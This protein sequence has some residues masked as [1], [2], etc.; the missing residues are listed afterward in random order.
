MERLDKI[1]GRET[2]YSRKEVKILIKNKR[3]KLNDKIVHKSDIKISKEDII[4]LDDKVIE[5][6]FKGGHYGK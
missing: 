4:K 1:I 2:G 5:V 6:S 3:I